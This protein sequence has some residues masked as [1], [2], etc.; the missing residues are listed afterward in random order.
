MS[1]GSRD[2]REQELAEEIDSHLRMAQQDRM[3]RG[4]SQEQAYYAARRE[5]GNESL[6]KEVTR[7]IWGGNWM[8]SWLQDLRYGTRVLRR[9]PS[10]SLIAIFTLALGISATT[11]IFSVV[12]GVLL[13]PL[14]FENP[15][16]LVHVWERTSKGN[17]INLADPN[18]QDLREQNHTLQGLAEFSSWQQPV[19]QGTEARRLMVATVSKDF[20]P[21]LHV[22][23]IM[24]RNFAA[25]DQ[26]Q[27]AAPVVVVS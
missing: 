23:P 9:N 13:R 26:R 4:E 11:A 3:D 10:F 5:M 16:Q 2:R 21:L 19:S 18:F 8:S 24:G 7:G 27:G 22:T 12:Y 14:P 6:I 1:F 20:L 15:G 25:E 17:S